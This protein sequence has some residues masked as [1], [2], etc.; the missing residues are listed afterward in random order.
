MAAADPE[1]AVRGVDHVQRPAAEA[2]NR[3]RGWGVATHPEFW[4]EGFNACQP[5]MILRRFFL[6]VHI[7]YHV[8]VI[9]IGAVGSFKLI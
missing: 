7:C 1:G 9:F 2:P 8:Q 6:I 3:E 5:P 4:K